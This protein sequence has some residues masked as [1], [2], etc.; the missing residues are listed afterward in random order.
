MTKRQKR[1]LK[2][3]LEAEKFLIK[4]GQMNSRDLVFLLG[5][6]KHYQVTPM[7]L[8]F[9]LKTSNRVDKISPGVYQMK[10]TS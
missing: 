6:H 1:V 7:Q 3:K 4:N 9:I 10:E 8:A 2:I 5:K